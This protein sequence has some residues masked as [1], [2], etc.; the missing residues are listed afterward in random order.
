MTFPAIA[1]RSSVRRP[2][3]NASPHTPCTSM[4]V[5][6]ASL[7]KLVPVQVAQREEASPMGLLHHENMRPMNLSIS[8]G[9][10]KHWFLHW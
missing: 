6:H 10:G 1:R 9:T 5:L 8:P 7:T 4:H 2:E 3:H